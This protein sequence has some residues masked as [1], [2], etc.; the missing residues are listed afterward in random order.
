MI[1]F[2]IRHILQTFFYAI[3]VEMFHLNYR[4]SR[5]CVTKREAWFIPMSKALK[6]SDALLTDPWVRSRVRRVNAR[7]CCVR[8]RVGSA[9]AAAVAAAATAALCMCVLI[10]MT[11]R[12][13]HEV[14]QVHG[15]ASCIKAVVD[16]H[17]R[18]FC[19]CTRTN[20]RVSLTLN[21]FFLLF[22]SFLLL[23]LF[24]RSVFLSSSSSLFRGSL[25]RSIRASS[26]QVTSRII[27]IPSRLIRRIAY[28]RAFLMSNF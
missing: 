25:G 13:V 12:L 21:L 17:A 24:L 27:N 18:T 26:L 8:I 23:L 2:L 16:T 6:S 4:V 11:D 7:V 3:F 14:G 5:Y 28:V 10:I 1:Y 19:T 15:H 20:V 9:H 22:L